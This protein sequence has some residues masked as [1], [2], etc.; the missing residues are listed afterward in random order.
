MLLE[1]FSKICEIYQISS[2]YKK[3]IIVELLLSQLLSPNLSVWPTI[4]VCSGISIL[5][6]MH[7]SAVIPVFT[8]GWKFA[9][10]CF[11][12]FKESCQLSEW[13]MWILGTNLCS[14]PVVHYH[15]DFSVKY[16]WS[17]TKDIP[18]K[19]FLIVDTNLAHLLSSSLKGIWIYNCSDN[20]KKL[21]ISCAHTK[22]HLLIGG[23][24]F[25]HIHSATS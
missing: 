15:A 1:L 20:F 3:R 4:L 12:F 5:Y 23:E 9:Y 7:H 24:P 17:G 25:K 2:Y 18:R 11:F 8:V 10:V 6:C 16:R 14:L 19:L 13:E 22:S 21:H